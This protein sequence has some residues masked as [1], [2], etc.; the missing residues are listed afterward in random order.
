MSAAS[1]GALLR[2]TAP[3]LRLN[4]PD[5]IELSERIRKSTRPNDGLVLNHYSKSPGDDS[6]CGRALDISEAHLVGQALLSHTKIPTPFLYVSYPLG[7]RVWVQ[8]PVG[9]NPVNDDRGVPEHAE[10]RLVVFS[11]EGLDVRVD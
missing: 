11:V 8:P 4:L 6:I 10:E 5:T 3:G 7:W 9:R 2:C 1:N